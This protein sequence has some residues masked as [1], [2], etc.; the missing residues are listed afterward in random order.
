MRTVHGRVFT[1]ANWSGSLD[2][3]ERLL[4]DAL[5][6]CG[7]TLARSG[8]DGVFVCSGLPPGKVRLRLEQGLPTGAFLAVA[9]EISLGTGPS[10]VPFDLPVRP[11]KEGL[12]VAMRAAFL[13]G[14]A[15]LSPAGL[16][17]LRLVAEALAAHPRAEATITALAAPADRE[18]LALARAR[19][20]AVREALGSGVIGR[21][22]L[23]ARVVANG[24]GVEAVF[25][26]V[27]PP[28]G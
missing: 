18:P 2:A 20:D 9:T 15:E 16:S 14:S 13:N 22:R 4:P 19:S 12:R 25:D 3:G 6:R 27:G 28:G 26:R 10:A 21:V 7:D 17:F 8:G 1:D 5:V 24:A 23:G 11:L